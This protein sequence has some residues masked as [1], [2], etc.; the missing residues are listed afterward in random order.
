MC[1]CKSKTD[2]NPGLKTQKEIEKAPF[3]GEKRNRK[4]VLPSRYF[5]LLVLAQYHLYDGRGTKL[6]PEEILRFWTRENEAGRGKGNSGWLAAALLLLHTMIYG[7]GRLSVAAGLS[8]ACCGAVVYICMQQFQYL[9]PATK[10][11]EEENLHV[12]LRR[13]QTKT[14]EGD[15]VDE[16]DQKEIIKLI[17]IRRCKKYNKSSSEKERREQG[18]SLLSPNRR[19]LEVENASTPPQTPNSSHRSCPCPADQRYRAPCTTPSLTLRPHPSYPRRGLKMCRSC[20]NRWHYCSWSF[21]HRS[22]IP[23]F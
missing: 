18:P 21:L 20:H 11:W 16:K 8:V 17:R 15:H 23:K 5:Q 9:I 13:L 22:W 14:Q 7:F 1:V 3:W 2:I 6:L 4:L 10:A 19:T 12:V